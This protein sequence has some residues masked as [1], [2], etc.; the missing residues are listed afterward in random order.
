MAHINY[1]NSAVHQK[2]F[3]AS[4]TKKKNPTWIQSHWTATVVLAA[5]T[6]LK[7]I[8]FIFRERGREED[9]ERNINVWMLLSP[10][11]RGHGLPPRHVP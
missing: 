9:R 1:K 10:P 5:V 6:F 8:L 7:K 2:K 3:F 4:L 11:Y